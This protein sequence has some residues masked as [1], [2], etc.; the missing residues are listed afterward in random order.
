MRA[1]MVLL[2]AALACSAASGQAA[3]ADRVPVAEA[4]RAAAA[5]VVVQI[6]DPAAEQTLVA[7]SGQGAAGY[8]RHRWRAHV[9]RVV[10]GDPRAFA[11]G[12]LVLIDQHAWRADLAEHLRCKG[13]NCRWPDKPQMDTQLAR[14]P[15]AGQTVLALLVQTADGWQLAFENGFDAPERAGQLPGN[16][17]RR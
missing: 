11:P 14:P 3:A 4:A 1:R 2:A 5:A 6:G 7:G 15:R 16:G 17:G 8:W 10:A 13:Q 9:Q 12:A